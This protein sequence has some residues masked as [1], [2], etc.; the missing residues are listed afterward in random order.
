MMN[1]YIDVGF[2][3]AP[4]VKAQDIATLVRMQLY[5]VNVMKIYIVM[6]ELA[7]LE[8][9]IELAVIHHKGQKD[10]AGHPYILH[11]L[12]LMMSVDDIDEKIVA[13]LHD[14]VEDTSITL[15][16]LRKAGFGET[17]VTAVECV[18]KKDGEGYDAFIDRISYN[19]IATHVK[20]AD[21][22]DNMDLT[23]LPKITDKDLERFKKYDKA[24]AK[25]K[26][27]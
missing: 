24:L 13:V 7:L 18:T 19:P 9:A 21:L 12:R 15:E 22:E 1:N 17:V 20:I 10:K 4:G 16:D 26:S 14:I 25:L 3:R 8:K 5:T 11:P 6:S 2:A 27:V 23:R